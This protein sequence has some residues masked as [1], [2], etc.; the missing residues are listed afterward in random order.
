[1]GDAPGSTKCALVVV[2]TRMGCTLGVEPDEADL[3]ED[4]K[5]TV[6]ALKK[7]EPLP[8]AKTAWSLAD[9]GKL[10]VRVLEGS[11]DLLPSA[12]MKPTPLW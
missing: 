2:E 8:R 10:N 12:M 11:R 1:M 5:K 9:D 7:A 3:D 4:L 6:A